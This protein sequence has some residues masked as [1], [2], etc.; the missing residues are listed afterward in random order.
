M[1]QVAADPVPSEAAQGSAASGQ[2]GADVEAGEGA[3]VGVLPLK[4]LYISRCKQLARDAGLQLIGQLCCDTLEELVVRNAG[5]A[6]G[7]VLSDRMRADGC[8]PPSAHG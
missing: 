7:V 8:F 4:R 6:G 1:Q 2:G 3:A 5:G